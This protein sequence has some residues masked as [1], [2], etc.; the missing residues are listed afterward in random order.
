MA[1]DAAEFD[2]AALDPVRQRRVKP[3]TAAALQRMR[4]QSR[5]D[6]VNRLAFAGASS[7]VRILHAFQITAA[8]R[9]DAVALRTPGGF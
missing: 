7:P 1:A 2:T 4:H 5:S 9:P 6:D 3:P 8:E